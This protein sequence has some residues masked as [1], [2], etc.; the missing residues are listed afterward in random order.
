MSTC[1]PVCLPAC[2]PAYLY[3]GTSHTFTNMAGRQAQKVGLGRLFSG[4]SCRL[5]EVASSTREQQRLDDPRRI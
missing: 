1:L 5:N 4:S 3:V 2:L